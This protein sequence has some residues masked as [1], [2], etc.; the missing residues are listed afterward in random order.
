MHTTN[1]RVD[2]PGTHD[3]RGMPQG[4]YTRY[5]HD[6]CVSQPAR[7]VKLR[8]MDQQPQRVNCTDVTWQG[9][10]D[11]RHCGIRH[12]VLFSGLPETAFDELLRPIDN[13]CYPSGSV[14]FKEGQRNKG[15]FSLRGGMVKLQSLNSDGNQ[16]IVRLLGKGAAIG[17]EL[18]D[19]EAC[20][21]HTAVAL[22]AVDVCRIP[23]E[24]M[25]HLNTVY[26]ELCQ[27]VRIRLQEN[28][29]WLDEWI[30]NLSSGTARKRVA[31]LLLLILEH[32]GNTGNVIALMG[33]EDMAAIIGTSVETASRIIAD[34]K[35]RGILSKTGK[36]EYQCDVAALK[37][38]TR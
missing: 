24:T 31:H 20:Y 8:N 13:I 16:R 2:V 3:G 11:C 35:R 19:E 15:I 33:R 12:L 28:I 1:F 37:A 30:M 4:M 17:L 18:L 29:D 26:P 27:Q 36:N 7:Y 23:L 14:L 9:R 34:L 22:T 25:Q 10:A 38:M 32:S 5:T 21:R 6:P